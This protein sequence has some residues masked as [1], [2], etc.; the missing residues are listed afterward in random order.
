MCSLT[1]LNKDL[2]KLFAQINKAFGD[3]TVRILDNAE[4][5][6]QTVST[7]SLT[8][9]LALGRG[10]LPR[11]RMIEVYGPAMAG[12]TTVC[13]LHLAEWQAKDEGYVAFIDAEHSFDPMLAQ[14]YGVDLGKLIFVQPKSAENA[15]DTAEALVRSGQVRAIVIDSV[16]ALVPTKIVESSIE[17][18][19]MGLLARFMSTACQKLDGIA[20]ANDCQILW[21][22]QIREKIGVMYGSPETTS[23]GRALPFYASVRLNV[24][25]G[26]HIKEKDEVIG[27]YVKV[28][29]S[30]NKVGIPFKEAMFPLIYGKGVDRI[31]EIVEL[32]CLAGVV[33]Q[34]GAW[35]SYRDEKDQVIER[36][37]ITYKW[38]GKANL[39]EFVRQN[40]AFYMEL[41]EILRGAKVEAP[42]GAP[43]ADQEGYE[44]E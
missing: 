12:K 1:G 30:K 13:S 34:A 23:G 31:Y 26:E 39:T 22:N 4:T 9:D 7:G 25:M 3:G 2:D 32:A 16:S 28:K 21:I 40:P 24:R 11:G 20:A 41:D 35:F 38:Q 15:I 6:V 27:H 14:Q 17:Q 33:T 10:G 5:F 43:V 36:G 8:L 29:V 42:V 44:E 18:Q 37:G 19:T